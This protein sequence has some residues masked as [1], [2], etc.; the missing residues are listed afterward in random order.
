MAYFTTSDNTKIFY[1]I[2]G[3]GEQ[4]IL[5]SCGGGCT[6]KY[7]DPIIPLLSSKCRVIRYDYRGHGGTD[8]TDGVIDKERVVKDIHE[9]IEHLNIDHLYLAGWSLGAMVSV[10]YVDIYGEKDIDGIIYVDMT[11]LNMARKPEDKIFTNGGK[12]DPGE[13]INMLYGYNKLDPSGE[14]KL[15]RFFGDEPE[16]HIDMLDIFKR[17]SERVA[18]AYRM[19]MNIMGANQDTRDILKEIELPILHMFG[20]AHKVKSKVAVEFM[21]EHVKNIKQVS[22]EGCGHAIFMENPEKF[23]EEVLD[24]I[25]I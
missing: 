2:D 10:L 22:F 21:R 9:L 14:N 25:H 8:R 18:P 24:F 1:E 15:R 19:A 11:P 16:K 23:A 20:T 5:F 17:E 3:E 7:Y 13:F 6:T 12:V 4:T